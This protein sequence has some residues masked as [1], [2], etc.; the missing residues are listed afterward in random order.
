M[1]RFIGHY[2]EMVVAMFVGMGVLAL[3]WML[4][5]PGLDE[6]PVANTLVMA[7]NM[8][9]GMAAWMALRG[10]GRQMIVEMSAAMVAP[11]LVLL[12]PYAAGAITADTLMMA[13]HMLMFLTMLGAMV[14]RRED[15]VNHHGRPLRRRPSAQA[16]PAD[17]GVEAFR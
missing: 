7:A 10:H 6:D 17:D 11:F 4:L 14:L 13:G 2:V 12:V 1:K 3:P 15:Y 8:T 16:I 9:I 5:W